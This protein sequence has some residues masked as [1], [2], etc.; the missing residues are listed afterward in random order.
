LGGF[1]D[2][3]RI[4]ITRFASEA[5]ARTATENGDVGA[6]FVLP[7]G[8]SSSFEA[9]RPAS[10][11]VIG[12]VDNPTTTQIADAIANGYAQGVR[13]STVAAVTAMMSGAITTAQIP[14]A[15][16][17]AGS[18][19]PPVRLG[20]NEAATRQLDSATYFVAGLSIFFIFFIAG[21]S[22]TSM[23]EERTEG[24]LSRLLAAPI[25]RGSI[26]GGKALGSVI[27][28]AVSM[29]VLVVASTL[30]M[31]A[32]WGAPLGVIILVGCAVLAVVAIMSAVG[33]L[34]RTA[35]QAGNLQSIVAVTLAM[36]GGTFVP[37]AN[38]EGLLAKLTYATPNAWFIRGLGEL[39]GGGVGAALPAAGVL[40]AMAAVFGILGWF[41]M[42]KAVAL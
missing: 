27:I 25:T 29:T 2:A 8:L 16:A 3:G 42:R 32:D 18:A 34:A 15:A 38:G 23:L 36:L 24:T 37:I 4:E 28:A 11:G 41:G 19:P 26:V 12:N 35:E 21:M 13:T 17:E 14:D 20:T 1:S 10:I 33:G 31:G 6:T 30:L 40:I 5:Q 9:G 22:V 7:A 39:S